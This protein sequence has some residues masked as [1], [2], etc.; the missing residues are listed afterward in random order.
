MDMM[1]QLRQR[2]EQYQQDAREA[3]RKANPWDGMLGFGND[4]R[5]NPCHERFYADV[6]AWTEEF[7]R[8]GPS[9]AEAAEAVRWMLQA[10]QEH[11]DEVTFLYLF[12][13]QGHARK[14]IPLMAAEDCG[15][16]QD[17]YDGAYRKVERM[18]VQQE[19]Y[20]LLKQGSRRSRA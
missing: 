18:P 14:L 16:L 9:A 10:A 19:V 8:R 17:W 2:Y 4:P 5:R 13:A 11:R 3:V 1:E 12:A 7:L 15:M 6:E 20:K